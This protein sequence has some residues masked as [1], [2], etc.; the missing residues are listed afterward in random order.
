[1]TESDAVRQVGDGPPA[2]VRTLTADLRA[3]GVPRGGTVLVHSSLRAL[4][5]VVGGAEAVVEALLA[6][7]GPDGTL[8]VPSF[9]TGRTE[10]SNWQHPPVPE[11]WWP[12]I[13]A[14]TPPYDPRVSSTRQMGAIVDCVLRWPGARRSA[15]PH[16]SFAALGPLAS[17][18][19]EP[20]PLPYGVGEESPLA[21]LYDLDAY[22]LLL[23]VGHANN[24][25][26]HLAEHRADFPGKETYTE[27]AAVLRDGRREWA[28]FPDLRTSD[29]DF[30][31]VGA[32]FE[33][34]GDVVT[35][36]PVGAG[37]ARLMRI[38]PLVD[39]GAAEIARRRTP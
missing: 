8:V 29:E 27:G 13:R 33:A 12:V 34:T 15:H 20:H 21:R 7:L 22:V 16:L 10:P 11:S 36:G 31:D 6:A 25:S 19:L 14:E 32:A 38:R 24:T 17:S 26:L 3:L 39:F 23:G 28:T 37:T 18:V 2:T 9:S 5:W 1:V 4:G 35:V 30:P